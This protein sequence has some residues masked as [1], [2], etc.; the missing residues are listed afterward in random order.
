M[1][2]GDLVLTFCLQVSP[3]VFHCVVYLFNTSCLQPC[4]LS[5]TSLLSAPSL[6]SVLSPWSCLT[7]SCNRRAQ[8]GSA[9]NFESMNRDSSKLPLPEF[10]MS[11]IL[12]CLRL[13]GTEQ[14]LI[15]V[16]PNGCNIQLGWIFGWHY[17]CRLYCSWQRTGLLGGPLLLYIYILCF[18]L[19]SFIVS[20]SNYPL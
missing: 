9:M 19:Y 14:P 17:I 13:L 20:A 6:G 3:T 1:L 2:S 18:L 10:C 12:V 11:T 16:T 5:L 4:V 8:K 7:L 15:P